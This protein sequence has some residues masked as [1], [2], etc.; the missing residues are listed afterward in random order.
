M[1]GWNKIRKALRKI[2]DTGDA[3]ACQVYKG[4]DYNGTIQAY[5]WYY[6]PFNR[7]PV[8]LGGSVGQALA[9]IEDIA[10]SREEATA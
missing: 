4:W 8:Y 7:Q 2:M 6:K 10:E 5:G 9:T 3:N 1:K